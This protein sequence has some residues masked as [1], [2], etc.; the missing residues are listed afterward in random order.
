MDW[1]ESEFSRVVGSVSRSLRGQ[2]SV[3]T[4]EWYDQLWKTADCAFV[5][6]GTSKHGR[7]GLGL[8]AGRNG[9]ALPP[10]QSSLF[11]LNPW[12]LHLYSQVSRA[13]TST[14]DSSSYSAAAA[15]AAANF[16]SSLVSSDVSVYSVIH[17]SL[18]PGSLCL[19]LESPRPLRFFANT[20]EASILLTHDPSVVKIPSFLSFLFFLKHHP[21]FFCLA[22][23]S[24][25]SCSCDDS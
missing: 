6:V 10:A 16:P 11:S 7:H 14:S 5:H 8:T 2:G 12:S 4:H 25:R 9:W 17:T 19:N 3:G 18:N 21:I 13:A 20:I 23:P 15:A 22:A 24:V 1:L